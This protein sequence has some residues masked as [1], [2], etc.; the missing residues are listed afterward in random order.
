VNPP[1]SR[2]VD[3]PDDKR[4][5][6]RPPLA[7]T[8]A[9]LAF[10]VGLLAGGDVKEPASFALAAASGAA[11]VFLGFAAASRCR[12]LSPKSTVQRTRL[13]LLSLAAGTGL[14]LANLSANWAIAKTDPTLRALL[15]ERFARVEPLNGLV[16]SPL[17]EEVAVRLFFMSV[18][19]WVVFRVTKRPTLA[20]AIALA[21]SALFFAVL[22]L[23]RPLP[24]DPVLANYYRA[25]L[26]MKY[27]LAGVALGWIFW[28]WGLPYSILCHVAANGAHLVFQGT[29][30]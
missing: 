29:V 23:A 3:L 4:D 16:A 10:M 25:A 12:T 9:W 6:A 13:V 2:H 20:F 30:L 18:M 7:L 11:L 5:G 22:H 15:I 8:A 21:G 14:G 19:A 27:A 24:V 28:R 26:V 17:V 1:G